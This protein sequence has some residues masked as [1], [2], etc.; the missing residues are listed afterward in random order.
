[1]LKVDKIDVYYGNI[2]A[3]KEV[4]L[5]VSEGEIVTLIG[6]N[7]AGKSTLL[8][9]LSG[10]L[11]PKNGE[12][13][14]M[15]GNIAGKP[16]QTIVKSG[17]SH[18]PEGRRVFANMTVEENLE[19]G[20]YLR[21]DKKEIRNDLDKVYEIFPRLLER[22]KQLSGTLSGG[23]QQMLAMGRAIM[24][25]PKLLLLDEPSMGLA[26]LMVKTIFTTIEEINRTGTTILL[27]EQNANMA[28]S[29]ANQAYVIETGRV[30]VSGTAKEL[31]ASEQIKQ[32]Y[33]GGI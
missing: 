17:I 32:A 6:A 22:R 24:A 4:S 8:K 21:K 18:V 11:K 1:M 15:G 25:R 31:Q 26:P 2:Q 29:I 16:A 5:E 12:I 9:T 10:L 13:Q 7:G 33:L 23:E 20:A 19:L 14:Y 27:V 28:L 30:V 3:L